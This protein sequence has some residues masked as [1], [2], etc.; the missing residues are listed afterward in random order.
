MQNIA[1]ILQEVSD[2]KPDGNISFRSWRHHIK[3][4]TPTG[5]IKTATVAMEI[6]EEIYY[7]HRLSEDGKKKFRGEQLQI[8]Y[9]QLGER[10]GYHWRKIRRN[11]NILIDLNIITREFK[12]IVSHDRVLNNVMY[13][14]INPEEFRKICDPE[15]CPPTKPKDKVIKVIKFE[16]KTMENQPVLP[17]KEP[18]ISQNQQTPPTKI[19]RTNTKTTTEITSRNSLNSY[20]YLDKLNSLQ[21]LEFRKNFWD[22]CDEDTTQHRKCLYSI[23]SFRA[24]YYMMSLEEIIESLKICCEKE[25]TGI[26][27]LK[28]LFGIFRA[29]CKNKGQG[30]RGYEDTLVFA[31][32]DF[33]K[34]RLSEQMNWVKNYSLD[35]P[36]KTIYYSIYDKENDREPVGD[37]FEIVIKD[38]KKQFNIDLK[39]KLRIKA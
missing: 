36:N 13:L 28:Y 4:Q 34:I 22:F 26:S 37:L 27:G 14:T 19:G 11:V 21:N 31:L 17:K 24:D 35:M 25:K 38:V 9:K 15:N 1:R 16:R 33:L 6:L 20:K 29:K 18:L 39:A 10:L 2:L 8:S 30:V 32:E 23:I 12:D 7:W 5:Q 3:Y